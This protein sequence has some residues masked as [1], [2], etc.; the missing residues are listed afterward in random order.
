MLHDGQTRLTLS[1]CQWRNLSYC[2]ELR[3][4]CGALSLCTCA[5]PKKYNIEVSLHNV[6]IRY[7]KYD[8]IRYVK[9]SYVT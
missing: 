8:T 3:L 1:F 6:T 5:N 7:N 2:M 9:L 4:L